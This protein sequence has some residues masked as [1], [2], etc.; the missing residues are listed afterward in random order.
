MKWYLKRE[1]LLDT[2]EHPGLDHYLVRT[3]PPSAAVSTRNTTRPWCVETVF[4]FDAPQLRSEQEARGVKCGVA[5][6]VITQQWAA[7]EIYP[8]T[9]N[10]QLTIT[11]QQAAQ[12]RLFAP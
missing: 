8:W 9:A 1:G 5:S 10:M 2:T 7:T 6:S 12:L 11:S 3:G 4:P